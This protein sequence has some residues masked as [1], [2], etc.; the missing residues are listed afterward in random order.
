MKLLVAIASTLVTLTHTFPHGHGIEDPDTLVI[1]RQDT[2]PKP[3]SSYAVEDEDREDPKISVQLKTVDATFATT[4]NATTLGDDHLPGSTF[5]DGV[6]MKY[7][8]DKNPEYDVMI[9]ANSCEGKAEIALMKWRSD[10]KS[11]SAIFRS[12]CYSRAPSRERCCPLSQKE[13]CED[14]WP[15][16]GEYVAPQPSSASFRRHHEY[17]R[18]AADQCMLRNRWQRCLE[19]R[20]TCGKDCKWKNLANGVQWCWKYASDI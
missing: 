17:L 7:Y 2:V 16:D 18:E 6:V 14:Y 12:S 9:D 15:R 5:E 13:S 10:C 19:M 1:K 8:K 20:K 11:F 4:E 3:T